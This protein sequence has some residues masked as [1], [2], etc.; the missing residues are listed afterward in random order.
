MQI[1]IRI[2]KKT[3]ILK[4]IYIINNNLQKIFKETN[5]KK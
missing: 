3:K 5:K 1:I 2:I 4:K